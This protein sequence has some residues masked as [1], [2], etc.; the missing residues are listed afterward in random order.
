MSEQKGGKQGFDVDTFIEA[1]HVAMGSD[2]KVPVKTFDAIVQAGSQNTTEFTCVVYSV[3]SNITNLTERYNLV[4]SDGV[5]RVPAV[6]STVNVVMT[7]V[8]N[9][10]I[11]KFTDL[12][13]HSV[14]INKQLHINDGLTQS[15]QTF[16]DNEG[17]FGGFVK[18]VDPIDT[19]QG[20]LKKLNNLENDVND[21]KSNLTQILIQANLLLT[22]LSGLGAAPVP[23]SMLVPYYTQLISALTPY[24]NS[25]LI[26]TIQS[27]LE[28]PNL[29]HGLSILP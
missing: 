13:S 18:I 24:A 10:Y 22:A 8:T 25:P 23:A 17:S 29:T 27:E 6:D 5:I 16:G 7:S 26:P 14:G 11:S 20:L 4:I 12:K 3:D 1:V 28:N 2:L 19:N 21:L 9:P 15:F